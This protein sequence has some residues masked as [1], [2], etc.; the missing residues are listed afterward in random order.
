MSATNANN[1]TMT[2]TELATLLGKF[3]ATAMVAKA[4]AKLAHDRLPNDPEAQHLIESVSLCLN[5]QA[6]LASNT[7][8][9]LLPGSVPPV[10]TAD[11]WMAPELFE[12]LQKHPAPAADSATMH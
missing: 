5:F 1:I 11:D 8:A 7:E 6:M 9:E 10:L 4:V 12:L 3:R 2:A